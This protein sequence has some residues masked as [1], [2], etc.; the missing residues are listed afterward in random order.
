MIREK[1]SEL[2]TAFAGVSKTK[3]G[4]LAGQIDFSDQFNILKSVSSWLIRR[5]KLALEQL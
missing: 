3:P 4:P 1:H 5:Q 2:T